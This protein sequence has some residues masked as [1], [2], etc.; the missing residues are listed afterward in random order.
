MI[1]LELRKKIDLAIAQCGGNTRVEVRNVAGD[2]DFIDSV[3]MVPVP[4]SDRQSI[5]LDTNNDLLE[6][7][8]DATEF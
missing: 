2:L 5:V 6:I 8:T 4:N 3:M 1:L 7:D